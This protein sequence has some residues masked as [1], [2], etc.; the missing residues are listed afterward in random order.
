MKNQYGASFIQIIISTLICYHNFRK[1][2]IFSHH[3]EMEVLES[4]NLI[5]FDRKH[6]LEITTYFLIDF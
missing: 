2:Y 3:S 4:S 5:F 1:M 6:K